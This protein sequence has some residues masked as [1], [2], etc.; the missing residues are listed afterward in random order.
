MANDRDDEMYPR[1]DD[2]I[3]CEPVRELRNP[4]TGAKEIVP[5][6]DLTGLVYYVSSNEL[7]ESSAEAV[8]PDLVISLPQIGTTGVYTATLTGAAKAARLA[9]QADSTVLYEHWQDGTRYHEVASFIW[10][11]RRVAE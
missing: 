9:A 8:H 11:K 7:A 4:T 5:I 1:N 6:T 3:V 2:I 10:R